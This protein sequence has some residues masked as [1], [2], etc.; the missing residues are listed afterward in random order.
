MAFN[1]NPALVLSLKSP[2]NWRG[3]VRHRL[4]SQINYVR[5]LR[6]TR[7]PKFNFARNELTSFDSSQAVTDNFESQSQHFRD[8]GWAFISDFFQHE[9]HQ[10]ILAAWPSLSSFTIGSDPTKSYDKGPRWSGGSVGE[11]KP[12]IHPDFYLGFQSLLAREFEIRVSSYCGDDVMRKN[13]G[14][15]SA[16]ARAGSLLLPHVDDVWQFGRGAVV[17]FVIFIDGS[18]PV[19]NSGATAIYKT[20]SFD[21]PVFVPPRLTNTALVYETGRLVYHG[22]PRVGRGKFSKRLIAQYSPENQPKL[23]ELLET[24]N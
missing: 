5:L 18:T 3:I 2:S 24:R 7:S 20:N 11:M 17:N 21:Y 12:G 16:W 10:A 9:I 14:L 15:A 1:I 13:S 6:G 23:S 4:R 19:T 22:F 8:H